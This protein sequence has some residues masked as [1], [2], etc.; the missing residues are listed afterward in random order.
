MLKNGA[1]ASEHQRES[2]LPMSISHCERVKSILSSFA[3]WLT[4][5]EFLT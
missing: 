5:E 1:K 3:E 2:L 4:N